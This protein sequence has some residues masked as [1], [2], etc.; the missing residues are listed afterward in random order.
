MEWQKN[1]Y[2]FEAVPPADAWKN[3]KKELD[4]DVPKIR[5]LLTDYTEQPPS[6]V[7]S[8]ISSEL[9]RPEKTPVIWFRKPAVV[10]AA[11]ASVAALVLL[12]SYFFN[13][14]RDFSVPDVSASVYKPAVQGNQP[15]PLTHAEEK[16]SMEKQAVQPAARVFLPPFES[17]K[18][19]STENPGSS[20]SR[21]LAYDPVSV[22]MNPDDENYIYLVTN[23]GEVKR[24]SYKLEKMIAE[25]RKQDGE[26][27]RKWTEK[28]EKSAFIPTGN[29]FFD[30]AEMVRII[31]E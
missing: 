2:Q 21:S 7:W 14:T 3:V 8:A 6:I 20:S 15:K 31:G 25:I 27:L 12:Y 17:S 18:I 5:E 19:S 10:T 22:K 26:K 28:L 9:D 13:G 23:S 30:I 29:N 11:A 1:L 24:V 4:S 16:D